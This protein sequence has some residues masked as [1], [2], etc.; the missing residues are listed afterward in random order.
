MPSRPTWRFKDGDEGPG[1]RRDAR[2]RA[3]YQG[4]QGTS[5]EVSRARCR[6]L[7][8]PKAKG[9]AGHH[10]NRWPASAYGDI[11]KVM[12]TKS[13]SKRG[14]QDHQNTHPRGACTSTFRKADPSRRRGP[15]RW[16]VN[17][18]D[19]SPSSAKSSHPIIRVNAIRR[20]TPSRAFNINDKHI[21]TISRRLL[22][23]SRSVGRRAP[24]LPSR[25]GDKLR[26][27]EENDAIIADGCRTA[28]GRRSSWYHQGLDIDR[29][30]HLRRELSRRPPASSR[31][32]AVRQ[33]RWIPPRPKENVIMGRL[34]LPVRPSSTTAAFSADGMPALL[35]ME[36]IGRR[37]AMQRKQPAL[38]FLQKDTEARSATEGK[39]LFGRSSRAGQKTK[40]ERAPARPG[41]SVAC[42][43]KW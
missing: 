17:P 30:V 26:F 23:G 19:C 37:R 12:P 3:N 8:D 5:P 2:S 39:D 6:T 10:R 15:H 32:Q 41:R 25:A 38:D 36:E 28:T 29:F 21:E 18:H 24:N 7:R 33:A 16:P 27:R 22:R 9:P 11:A 35:P 31:K 20:F 34:I 1:R 13:T 40:S 42:A 4:T 14:W 43:E